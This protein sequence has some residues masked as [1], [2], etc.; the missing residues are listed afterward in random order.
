MRVADLDHA[1]D[2][3]EVLPAGRAGVDCGLDAHARR[4]CPDAVTDADVAT[5]EGDVLRDHAGLGVDADVVE[6]TGHS[7]VFGALVALHFA[8]LEVHAVAGVAHAQTYDRRRVGVAFGPAATEAAAPETRVRG[9]ELVVDGR[10]VEA[11]DG[12][13]AVRLIG[14]EVEV[15]V[16]ERDPDARP[17]DHGTIGVVIGIGDGPSR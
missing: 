1:V 15:P 4:A 13:V 17:N 6:A 8:V 9:V 10:L 11:H 7:G 14:A 2:E 16:E 5:V 12:H 3:A